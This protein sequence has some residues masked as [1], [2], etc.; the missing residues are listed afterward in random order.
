MVSRN[1]LC[2]PFIHLQCRSRRENGGRTTYSTLPVLHYD[3]KTLVWVHL[4]I[5]NACTVLG[6]LDVAL[7]WNYP[8]MVVGKI[9]FC[10]FSVYISFHT[11]YYFPAANEG[12]F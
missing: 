8:W 4:A 12:Y 7:A 6:A 2:R 1:V 10:G 5:G 11:A 9:G 3:E